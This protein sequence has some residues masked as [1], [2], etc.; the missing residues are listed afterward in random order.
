MPACRPIWKQPGNCCTALPR[1]VPKSRAYLSHGQVE[2]LA[3][4]SGQH[5]TLVRFL[6]YTGLRWGE[7]TGL[8]V[9][10]LDTLRRRLNVEE[11]AV[12]DRV[13]R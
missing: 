2:L 8:R 5:A 12:R 1:K 13:K 4:H 3:S 7:A 9:R 10:H 11:N 6:A